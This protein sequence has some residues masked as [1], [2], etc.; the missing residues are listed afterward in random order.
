MVIW[1]DLQAELPEVAAAG[2]ALL[3]QRGDGEALLATVRADAAPRIHPVNVG[4]VDGAL[5][6]FILRSAKLADLEAD[7]RYALHAHLDPQAPSEFSV[8]GRA[9]EVTDA[10]LRFSVAGEWPFTVDDTYRLYTFDLEAAA[11]GERHDP[12]AWPPRYTRWTAGERR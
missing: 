4:L 9:R 12:A 10:A 7:G 2:R 3:Y 1:A 8:R 5:F 11:L 6:A